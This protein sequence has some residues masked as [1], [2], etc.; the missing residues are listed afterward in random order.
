MRLGDHGKFQSDAPIHREALAVNTARGCGL[1]TPVADHQAMFR[2]DPAVGRRGRRILQLHRITEGVRAR[3]PAAVMR[4]AIPPARSPGTR[5]EREQSSHVSYDEGV[6]IEI[7]IE[8]QFVCL[9]PITHLPDDVAA[10]QRQRFLPVIEDVLNGID[11]VAVIVLP[12]RHLLRRATVAQ[13]QPAGFIAQRT[14][15]RLEKIHQTMLRTNRRPVA[16]TDRVIHRVI[17]I[18]DHHHLSVAPKAEERDPLMLSAIFG[19]R[20]VRRCIRRGGLRVAAVVPIAVGQEMQTV[21]DGFEKEVL[22]LAIDPWIRRA[23]VFAIG[24][25]VAFRVTEGSHGK[26]ELGIDACVVRRV[27][28]RD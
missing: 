12:R 15:I 18:V 20:V 24:N 5:G 10:R 3:V 14:A 9:L 17:Q 2:Y 4:E 13:Q 19:L 27:R 26:A 21:E 25:D 1:E 11:D 22:R 8:N 23:N 28:D 6:R 7:V 16:R